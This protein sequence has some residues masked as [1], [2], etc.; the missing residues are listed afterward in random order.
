[1]KL[2]TMQ[3]NFNPD[4]IDDMIN[5][6]KWTWTKTNKKIEYANIPCSFDIETTSFMESFEK[7]AIMY[8]WTLCLNGLIM[9]GRTWDQFI[10][11]Y[12]R[13]VS[14]LELSPDHRLILYV[15]NLSFEFQFI[16]KLLKWKNVF[17]VDVRKPVYALTVDGV[18]FR[19]S[20]LLS[21]YGLAKLGSELQKYK[22]EKLVGD[23]D[24]SKMRHSQTELTDQEINYCR[25]DCLVVVSYIQERI[26]ESGNIGLLPLTKTGYVRKYCRDC[27]LYDGTHKKNGW[28]YI[29]YKKLMNSLVMMPDE[30]Q[31]L[32]R[33]FQGGFTHASAWMSGR[34]IKNV[35][36]FD[37][38]SSYPAVMLSEKFPM[39]KAEVIKIESMQQFEKNLNLYCCLFDVEIIGLESITEIEHPLSVS[40]CSKVIKGIEDN[41]RLVSA[42]HLYT[43]WTEQDYFI[44]IKFYKWQ[45]IKIA[46]FRRYQR[47]YLPTD[48]IKG[49][50]KLYGDKT[51]LKGVH[52]KETEY[53]IAKGMLNST[54]GM[55]VTD[56]CRD[57]N[58]Y[59]DGEW[60]TEK[61]DIEKSI[62]KYNKSIKRFLFYPWGVWVTAYARKNLF[63]G[64][65]ECGND[66]VYSDT[67]SIK[68]ING[69]D[70][71]QYIEAY[72]DRIIKKL[73][74]AME[75]HGIDPETTRPKSI[76]GKVKQMGIWDDEGTYSRF[77]TLGAKRYLTEKNGKM[78]LTVSGLN[79]KIALPYM[80]Q[81]Y[82]DRIFDAF[83][84]DLYIPPEYTGKNTHTYI[85]YEIHGIL[86]DYNGK[87]AEYDELSGVH[88]MPADYSLTLSDAY[89]NYLTG[90][91][92]KER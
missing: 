62:S 77:K 32:K 56:I 33:A 5:K 10:Y 57:E 85:D 27:C 35:R 16:R 25:N 89:L 6:V 48:F 22:V 82:K 38:T 54:Y 58:I 4:E 44:M 39:S 31:Q 86:K 20:Y 84:D 36:S 88:L 21:G 40:R 51:M 2:Q 29:L 13:I 30:Y 41:G 55:A 12:D 28:K 3:K 71:M 23:L 90:I 74:A 87:Y 68:I 42:D 65:Y 8:E 78:E 83:T 17:S 14:D 63:T 50:L 80:Q 75:Y 79:K 15:H 76:D 72:N 59:K 1:M 34:V 53:Q 92:S 61:A 7:R 18:E 91:I 52:G 69:N 43:T 73:D 46:D 67:D 60:T 81:K 11:V 9:I 24:Y 45:H 49:I 47:D 70:H 66:Y 26:E 19:C 37:F 64:I